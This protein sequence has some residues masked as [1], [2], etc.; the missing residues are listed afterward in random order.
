[1]KK[2]ILKSIL[3]FAMIFTIVFSLVGCSQADRVNQNISKEANR[4]NVCR[5]ISVLNMRTDKP[6]FE[7]TGFF[8]IN[9]NSVNELVVT[10]EVGQGIYKKHYIYLNAWTMYVVEDLSGANVSNYHY[11]IN[12]LPEM[13]WPFEATTKD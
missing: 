11:E 8:S 5:R 1:M 13:I 6:I 12:F 3:C 4:F 10:C 7:L 2:K 9:N